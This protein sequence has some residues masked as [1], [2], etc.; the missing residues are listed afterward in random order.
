[1]ARYRLSIW[2]A[3]TPEGELPQAHT[4]TREEVESWIRPETGFMHDMLSLEG[5]GVRKLMLEVIDG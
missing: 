2:Y 5:A 1:M 3:S 4:L